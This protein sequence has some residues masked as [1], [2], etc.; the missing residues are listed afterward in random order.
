MS[1][2]AVAS[3]L[4]AAGLLAASVAGASSAAAL[5]ADA[6][7]PA[8]VT[9]GDTVPLYSTV[10]RD[11]TVTASG[12]VTFGATAAIDPAVGQPDDFT[13]VGDT[14]AN[15]SLPDTGTCVVTVEFQPF[16]TGLRT[17]SLRIPTT[18]PAATVTVA[19]S[20]TAVPDATGTYYNLPTPSR[21][22]DTR[23]GARVPNNGTRTVQIAGVT[24]DGYTMPPIGHISAV[25]VN[26]TAV[27]TSAKGYFTL[28]PNGTTLPTAST[29]NF[30]AGWTGA[31]MA[32]VPLGADG[33][34]SVFNSGG[35]ADVLVDVLGWYAK[36]DTV[37]AT[38]GLGTQFLP[39]ESGGPERYYNSLKDPVNNNLPFQDGDFQEFTDTWTAE[40]D[41]SAIQAYAVTITAFR[42]TASGHFTSGSGDVD[43][44]PDNVSNVNYLKGIAAPNMA[45]IPASHPTTLTTSFRIQNFGAGE[46]HMIVDLLGYY[47][48]D[49]S[50]GLRFKPLTGVAA[51]KR[52][53]DTRQTNTIGNPTGKFGPNTAKTAFAT[54]V[55]TTDS[56]FVVGNTTGV[57]P[58]AGTYLT[59]WSGEVATPPAAS[60]L[61]LTVGVN[62][63]VSTYAPLAFNG[64][65]GALTYRIYNNAGT[66]HV[67]FDAAGTLDLYPSS[68][69]VPLGALG[70]PE[71]AAKAGGR[72]VP[73]AGAL[74]DGL[75][76][77]TSR[78][79]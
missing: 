60:T 33:A 51:P 59:V 74:V 3:M 78:R 64:A 41:A 17:A 18:S 37:R 69:V 9:F 2:R 36:D 8:S 35:P 27:A 53:L 71:G 47:V 55:S 52:I 1:R 7:A 22:L 54:S 40:S 56:Y 28:Y 11:V 5:A 14:C 34:I 66:T 6:T 39:T 46:V 50:R 16:A 38:Y 75:E 19:L 31:N 15:N 26:L 68:A 13:V 20:G 23:P 65:T 4:G 30:P 73:G 25:V 72:T 49:A 70:A 24:K 58:S 29:I 44:L 10:Q 61:N 48:S 12:P 42:G 77:S 21:Y 45:I 32:T 62:R 43:P 76:G 63:A 79:G 67:L 57:V